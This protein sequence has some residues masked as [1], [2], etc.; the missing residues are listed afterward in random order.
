MSLGG[1]RDGLIARDGQ[2]HPLCWNQTRGAAA[3]NALA[4]VLAPSLIG[5]FVL[6][7]GTKA[8]PA[9]HL[10][11]ERYLDAKYAP[12]AVAEQTGVPAATIKRIAAEL[13]YAAFEQQ[14][15]IKQSWTDWAGRVHDRFIGRPV[16]MHAMRGISAHSN[17]FHTCRADHLL[18]MLLGSIDTPGGLALQA[19]VPAPLPATDPAGRQAWAGRGEY[20]AA[21]AA[22]GLS[23]RAGGFC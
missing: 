9:F 14:I 20:A 6:A 13:A 21:G 1:P 16:S 4:A 15:E 23:A 22:A 10:M 5:E 19:A 3:T 8:R 12:E 11:A 18:Q 17:G 2:G 7:D